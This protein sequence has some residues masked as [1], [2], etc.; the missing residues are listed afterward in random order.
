MTSRKDS[1]G[2]NAIIIKPG[3]VENEVDPVCLTFLLS[4][5]VISFVFYYLRL[6]FY[7]YCSVY[8]GQRYIAYHQGGCERWL[9]KEEHGATRYN[10]PNVITIILLAKK[11]SNLS[12]TKFK[13]FISIPT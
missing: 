1:P 12:V 9:N 13:N 2:A 6:F 7:I 10:I 4:V 11:I 5:I 8:F 3:N